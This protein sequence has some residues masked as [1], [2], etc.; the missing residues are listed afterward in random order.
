MVLMTLKNGLRG[1]LHPY[2]TAFFIDDP[3]QFL[4]VALEKPLQLT[5]KAV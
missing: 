4:L 2:L 3:E 5:A 1:E